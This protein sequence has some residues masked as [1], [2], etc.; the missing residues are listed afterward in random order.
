MGY[1]PKLKLIAYFP[2]CSRRMIKGGV[3]HGY[4]ADG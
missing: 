2:E 4:G 3:K 1:I